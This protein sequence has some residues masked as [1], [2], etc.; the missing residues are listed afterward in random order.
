MR[1]GGRIGWMVAMRLVLG[2]VLC[3]VLVSGL[4]GTL[5]QAQSVTTTNEVRAMRG[6]G[7]VEGTGTREQGTGVTSLVE[8]TGALMG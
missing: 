1:A 8:E 2:W 6:L 3:L 5:V 4:S 7:P